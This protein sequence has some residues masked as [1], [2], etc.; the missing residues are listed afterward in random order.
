M[1][2]VRHLVL[3]GL[4]GSGKTTVGR[5]VAERLGW[6]LVDSDA[7]IEGREGP[8]VRELRDALGT[9]ALHALEARQLL[10]ALAAAGP[11][12]ICAAASTIDDPR[13]RAAL[14]E[15]VVLTAWL[16]VS[17]EV[18]AS[19]F[20]SSA[21]RPAY[22]ADP[23]AFLAEQAARRDPLFR[24]VA[25]LVVDADTVDAARAAGSIVGASA[26]LRLARAANL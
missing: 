22:G 18:A 5:L 16:R 8:T 11:T 14:A 1:D 13:C 7:E 9:D 4:M 2:S 12:V 20:G 26:R 21:H 19:R 25:G 15:P 23:D 3:V 6:P 24:S 10:E 17:P